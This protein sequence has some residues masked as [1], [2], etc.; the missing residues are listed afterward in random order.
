[1]ASVRSN[2]RQIEFEKLEEDELIVLDLL[3]RTSKFEV[4]VAYMKLLGLIKALKNQV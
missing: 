3:Q 1:M 4:R 2:A